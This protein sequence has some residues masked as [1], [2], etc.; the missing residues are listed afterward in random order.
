MIRVVVLF[1]IFLNSLNSFSQSSKDTVFF[2][3]KPF[4]KHIVKTNNLKKKKYISNL[5]VDALT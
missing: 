4:I 3:G 2:E 1:L 5:G